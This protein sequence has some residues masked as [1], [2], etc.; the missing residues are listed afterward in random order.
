MSSPLICPLS[1]TPF[2]RQFCPSMHYPVLWSVP[3]CQLRSLVS[4]ALPC[5]AQSFGLSPFVSSVLSSVLPFKHWPVLWSVPFC[6]FFPFVHFRALWFVPFVSSALSCVAL[7]LG[8]SP[9]LSFVLFRQFCP[10][11]QVKNGQYST[12]RDNTSLLVCPILFVLSSVSPVPF[13]C[14]LWCIVLCIFMSF[15]FIR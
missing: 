12:S 3:F 10:L 1:S 4:S 9:F 11:R 13:S 8:V 6:L 7:S 5:I 14:L 2:S 15:A